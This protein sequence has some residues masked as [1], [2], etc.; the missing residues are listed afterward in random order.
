MI[1]KK[2]QKKKERREIIVIRTFLSMKCNIAGITFSSDFD[3]G[4]CDRVKQVDDWHFAVYTRNDCKGSPFANSYSTWFYFSMTGVPPGQNVRLTVRNM[5]VQKR[6]YGSF[7]MRPVVRS[8]PSRPQWE[9]SKT[10]CTFSIAESNDDDDDDHEDGEEEE[11]DSN[12]ESNEP[13][14]KFSISF[15]HR[16]EFG[17]SEVTYFAFCF[18]WSYSDCQQQL[19]ELDTRFERKGL[20]RRKED[21]YYVRE[22]L[23]QSTGGRRIDLIT[24]SSSK[25]IL[26]DKR[27]R[28]MDGLF[29]I[30]ES[31]TKQ[32]R[33][34]CFK[35]KKVILVTSRV[36]P[37]ETPASHM[38]NGFLDF[39]L[40]DQ[41]PRARILR[42]NFVFK[43]IPML[44]PDGVHHGHYRTDLRG[45]NLNR[46]YRDPDP[47]L[48]PSIFAVK[49]LVRYIDISFYIDLH[50]HCNKRGFFLFGN[51]LA[52]INDQIDNVMF[53]K[54][55][56]LNSPHFDFQACGFSAKNM[57][58]TSKRDGLS[59]D[60]TGRVA[61]YQETGLVHCYTVECNY[62]TGR[63]LNYI[64]P[65]AALEKE[66]SRG[67]EDRSLRRMKPKKS[68]R[69][70]PKY[71]IEIFHEMGEAIAVSL[72]DFYEINPYSRIP[73]SSY[74]NMHR[75]RG[76]VTR[77]VSSKKSS[78][79]KEISEIS[80]GTSSTS[81][82]IQESVFN[83]KFDDEHD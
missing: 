6:L 11:E 63:I 69:A 29:P 23:I 80:E 12:E 15:T 74:K 83:K 62:S 78:K 77:Y 82:T 27:E 43:L 59:K 35:K 13:E 53:P 66:G 3:S 37:G 57:T 9:R 1:T 81:S 49:E 76:S 32:E 31:G 71:T 48:H 51:N 21:I 67:M 52:D 36:H 47:V 8:V 46:L 28:Y 61:L 10:R 55:I 38:F 16:F 5:N 18:P 39:I 54:I 75:L 26:V 45:E 58:S 72:L 68:L 79:K 7:G 17:E 25:G 50:A 40:D 70:P 20:S 33:P 73:R 2:K 42:D 19:E 65:I 41:D 4:N 34:H 24:L 56:S 60:G 44:N 14:N 64:S 22:L 30:D